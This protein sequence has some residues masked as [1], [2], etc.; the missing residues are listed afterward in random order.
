MCL[1]LVLLACFVWLAAWAAVLAFQRQLRSFFDLLMCE[2]WGYHPQPQH[3]TEAAAALLGLAVLQ[4]AALG[5]YGLQTREAKWSILTLYMV[6]TLIPMGGFACLRWDYEVMNGQPKHS[7]DGPTVR[8]S[9]WAMVVVAL[10]FILVGGFY[11]AEAFG[12]EKPEPLKATAEE[13]RFKTAIA[14]LGIAKDELGV[15][16]KVPLASSEM[17][18]PL[19]VTVNIGDDFRNTWKYAG[20]AGYTLDTMAEERVSPPPV[21]IEG[22]DG[23]PGRVFWH[24]LVSGRAYELRVYLYSSTHDGK[25]AEALIANVNKGT[26]VTIGGYLPKQ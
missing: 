11:L 6:A 1:W 21:L 2:G 7:F 5:A 4:M 20:V 17:P 19:E 15:V 22:V 9:T 8:S 3:A 13:H 25:G 18:N 24:R 26:G 23:G 10:A 16:V 12:E 14:S